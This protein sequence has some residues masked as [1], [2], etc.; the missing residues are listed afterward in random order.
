MSSI[1]S[2]LCSCPVYVYTVL[3]VDVHYIQSSVFM[4]SI[5]SAICQC[6]VYTVFCVNVKYIQCYMSMSC[7]YSVLC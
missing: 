2:V 1:Y 7:I 4:S 6:R 3:C 5:Y